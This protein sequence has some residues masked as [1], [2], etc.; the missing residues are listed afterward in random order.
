MTLTANNIFDTL[1]QLKAGL[2]QREEIEQSSC[3]VFQDGKAMTF[4][5]EVFCHAPS[6]FPSEVIGA[7]PGLS[8]LTMLQE[9]GN[10]PMTVSSHDR[11]LIFRSRSERIGLTFK[12][13][14]LRIPEDEPK[15]WQP[16]PSDFSDAL[17]AVLPCVDKDQ[18]NYDGAYVHLHPDYFEAC[19]NSHAVRYPIAIGIRNPCL[20]S[21]K[22]LKSVVKLNPV[23]FSATEGW[24]HFR[25]AASTTIAC[26]CDNATEYV[27]LDKVF[28][29]SEGHRV[30][31]PLG[32]AAAAHKARLIQKSSFSPFD[33]DEVLVELRRGSLR[34]VGEGSRGWYSHEFKANYD[35]PDRSFSICPEFLAQIVSRVSGCEMTISAD[36]LR[37]QTANFTYV[38]AIGCAVEAA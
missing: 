13:V 19:N 5:D 8:M 15:V 9:L 35:G 26:R 28:D 25:N 7:I 27:S 20:V 1:N 12:P 34:L 33:E 21:G 23:E 32:V 22:G 17:R 4:N 18:S 10:Q 29:T 16:L 36:S 30:T 37:I 3:I 38:V 31:F 11:T 2:T 24:L 6:P 14:A